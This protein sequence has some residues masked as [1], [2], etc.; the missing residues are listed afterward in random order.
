MIKVNTREV[1]NRLGKY[2]NLAHLGE[3]VTVCKNGQPWFELRPCARPA[4]RPTDP[5]NKE[6]PTNS[7]EVV[8]APVNS[9]D[10]G[11]WI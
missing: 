10:L 3:T 4:P 7:E 2:G 8:L 9:E 11:G 5:L 1:K 6:R